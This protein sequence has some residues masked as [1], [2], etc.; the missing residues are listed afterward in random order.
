MR[1]S[2][3]RRTVLKDGVAPNPEEEKERRAK[4]EKKKGDQQK[5][6]AGAK[7]R[8]RSLTPDRLGHAVSL[9]KRSRRKY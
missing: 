8:A 1:N 7:A 3:L 2:D 9:G 5:N 6:R 4:K